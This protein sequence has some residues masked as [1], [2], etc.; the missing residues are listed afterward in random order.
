MVLLFSEVDH[1][2][3]D[4]NTDRGDGSQEGRIYRRPPNARTKNRSIRSVKINRVVIV[5][6]IV[7]FRLSL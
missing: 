2:S 1:E 5:T 6:H 3:E 7:S 4:P